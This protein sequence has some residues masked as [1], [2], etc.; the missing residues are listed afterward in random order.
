MAF[1][2]RWFAKREAIL[3]GTPYDSL[4][5][6]NLHETVLKDCRFHDKL[7]KISYVEPHTYEPDFVYERDDKIFYIETKGR[8]RDSGEARKYIFIDKELRHAP[9]RSELVFV[10]DKANTPF[11]F[12][13]RRKD[14]TRMSHEEWADKEGFRHWNKTEFNLDLL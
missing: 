4:L 12:S 6:K 7:D 13:K 9:K 14:G 2:K 8:F 11:P 1:K 5:E 10:W 3:K